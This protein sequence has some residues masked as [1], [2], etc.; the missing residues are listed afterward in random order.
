M[1]NGKPY[2]VHLAE[3]ARATLGAI[4]KIE[5]CDYVCSTTGQPPVSGFAKRGAKN[6]TPNDME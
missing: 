1:K 2:H 3:S 4:T 6:C 5:K